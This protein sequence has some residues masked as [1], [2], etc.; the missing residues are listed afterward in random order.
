MAINP[1]NIKRTSNN[2]SGLLSA[3]SRLIVL[4]FGLEK[5]MWGYF[6]TT[7]SDHFFHFALP[8]FELSNG[9]KGNKDDL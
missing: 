1:P 8:H 3:T 7:E 6:G 5:Y 4:H 9:E 2:Y